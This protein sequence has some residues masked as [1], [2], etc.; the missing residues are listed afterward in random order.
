LS[1]PETTAANLTIL[2][3]KLYKPRRRIANFFCKL[4]QLRAIAIRHDK[5]A[6][7]FLAVIYLAAAVI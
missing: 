3:R 1:R 5:I 2:T 4:K 7:N 6:R